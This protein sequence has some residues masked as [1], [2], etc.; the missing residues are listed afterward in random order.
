ML[1]SQNWLTVT[2][3]AKRLGQ[4]KF[5]VLG[6]QGASGRL[7][8]AE[9]WARGLDLVWPGGKGVLWLVPL[10]LMAEDL[11]TIDPE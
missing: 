6:H 3:P 11:V 8:I 5:Q 2:G 4:C 10:S 9:N 1:D 7:R